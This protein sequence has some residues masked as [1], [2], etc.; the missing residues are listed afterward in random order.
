MVF[1]VWAFSAVKCDPFVAINAKVGEE[2]EEEEEFTGIDIISY[3]ATSIVKNVPSGELTSLTCN[4]W[5][6]NF[7]I[8]PLPW[9]AENANHKKTHAGSWRTHTDPFAESK[10]E[11]WEEFVWVYDRKFIA[12]AERKLH[13]YEM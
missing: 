12:F 5:W 2:W 9:W 7:H 3:F 1:H 13:A 10:D 6:W 4:S 8:P 11:N